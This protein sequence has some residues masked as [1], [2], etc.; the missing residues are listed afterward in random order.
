MCQWRLW[1]TLAHVSRSVWCGSTSG[2]FWIHLRS[3]WRVAR[4]SDYFRISFNGKKR[5]SSTLS[6]TSQLDGVGGQRHAPAALPPGKTRY[7]LYGSLGGPQG[8]SGQVRKH[9]PHRDSIT[10]P[11]TRVPKVPK[12]Y[13]FLRSGITTLRANKPVRGSSINNWLSLLPNHPVRLRGPVTHP[14]VQWGP[15]DSFLG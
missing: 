10:G 3:L 1:T 9:R 13:N 15:G 12:I 11:S 4:S 2:K 8:W 14:P 6:L 5:Y 7:P